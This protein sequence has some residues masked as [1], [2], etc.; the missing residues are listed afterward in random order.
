MD[1]ILNDWTV[2]IRFY[3]LMGRLAMAEDSEADKNFRRE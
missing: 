1:G 3:G 2:A